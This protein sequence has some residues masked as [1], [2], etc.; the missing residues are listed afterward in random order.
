MF[1]RDVKSSVTTD[2]STFSQR[3][4]RILPSPFSSYYADKRIQLPIEVPLPSP[5]QKKYRPRNQRVRLCISTPKTSG[6]ASQSTPLARWRSSFQTLVPGTPSL[7]RSA[8]YVSAVFCI[9]IS[10]LQ[11]SSVT[12]V[13]SCPVRYLSWC[14]CRSRRIVCFVFF[15]RVR[16]CLGSIVTVPMSSVYIRNKKQK[17]PQKLI[18]MYVH[19]YLYT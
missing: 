5:P 16:L 14:V 2:G 6:T 19:I 7:C 13:V 4:N 11:C 18:Y 9:L 1:I 3:R 12:I 8:P 15:P 17:M 10:H